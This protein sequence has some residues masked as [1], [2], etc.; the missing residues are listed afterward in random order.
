MASESPEVFA[1]A[2]RPAAQ[3]VIWITG[4]S[5]AGKTTVGR[6]VERALR[7]AGYTT[8]FLDGDDLRSIFAQ[9][10]GYG[11]DERI[12]LA[13]VYFR[14]CSHLAAQGA[15]V[16]ISAVAMYAEVRDWF[17]KNVP[18]AMEV[19]LHVPEHERRRRDAATKRVYGAIGDVSTLYDEPTDPDLR[20]DNYDGVTPEQVADRIVAQYRAS[21][22]DRIADAGRR[23]HWQAFYRTAAAPA[24]PSS[25]ARAVAGKLDSRHVRL[26]EV[27][28][29]NG[30]DAAYFCSLG[31]AVTGVD[32]CDAAIDSC[33]T[34]HAAS[35]ARFEQG[36]LAE[37]A[38]RSAATF[39]VVYSR[40][41]L[42]AMS[43]EE[44]VEA[45]AAA[46]SLLAP[47]GLM[48]IECRSIN[49]P[50]ARLGEVISPTERIHGH[51]RRFIVPEE[52]KSRVS[53]AGFEVLELVES[54]GL[55]V[56]GTEDPVVIRL[57][58]RKRP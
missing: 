57:A 23:A 39:D 54:S 52:L 12:D 34:A 29:G 14:L 22:A 50:M 27:G 38:A 40:F 51:Y 2:R 7:S 20:I 41:C 49:D 24:Q 16:V 8:I 5:A 31:H 55:A 6:C 47:G 44:E 36:T 19:Y 48:Y 11:R 45:L 58:A 32:T 46:A 37:V 42:H 4:Y 28:C 30:R 33:R 53:A 43:R 35:G 3:G 25:F 18:H 1:F 9:R 13:R 15:T 21:S 17:R 26:I 10:W 56:F